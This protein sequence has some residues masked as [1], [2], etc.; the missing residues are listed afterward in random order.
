MYT[1]GRA[2]QRCRALP[3]TGGR[4]ARGKRATYAMVRTALFDA[5]L[6]V[7]CDVSMRDRDVHMTRYAVVT[8][9][10]DEAEYIDRTVA[11]MLRQTVT[12]QRW[13]VV[14]DGSTDDTAAIVTRLTADVPWVELVTRQDRGHRSAGTGVMEAFRT[15]RQRVDDLDWEFLV[16]LDGDL[17][18]PEDY[19]ELCFAAFNSNAKLGIAGGTLHDVYP[20]KIVHDSHPG[21][22]V[23]GAT[24]IYSRACWE[25]IGGLFDIPGWD[26]LDEAKANQMGWTTRTLSHP[27]IYQLRPT[28]SA[29]GS[30][31]NWVKNGAAAYRS[32]YHPAF[33]L[34]R[35][36]RRLVRP[37]SI[38]APTGL[39][40]GYLTS[41]IQKVE[42]I[43]D[44]ELLRYVRTQQW[45]RLTGK[46][47]MWK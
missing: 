17:E 42:R 2:E 43:D 36:G 1:F 39:M 22:H 35:A 19:F 11:S 37:P 16:K 41:W 34:A 24:K 6:A 8:P 40:W 18:F 46:P 28:G 31:K 32:G 27:S 15:G 7:R 3:W 10:R 47:S 23:R 25:G 9:V 30:W 44:P 45:N 21:F 5:D 20:D 33:V 14:D 4:R 13:V 38:A 12:P 29:A 26:T